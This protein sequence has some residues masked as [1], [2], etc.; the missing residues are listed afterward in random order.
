MYLYAVSGVRKKILGHCC[1]GMYRKDHLRVACERGYEPFCG[2]LLLAMYDLFRFAA[3]C[4]SDLLIYISRTG[5]QL[6]VE[7][8]T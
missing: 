4:S 2:N 8:L 1:K 7:H 5:T 6:R 3:V